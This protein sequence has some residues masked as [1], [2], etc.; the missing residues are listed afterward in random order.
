MSVSTLLNHSK[1]HVTFTN[2]GFLIQDPAKER[3]IGK[4]DLSHGLYFLDPTSCIML[5]SNNTSPADHM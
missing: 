2:S 3:V 1:Y 4:G 5:E